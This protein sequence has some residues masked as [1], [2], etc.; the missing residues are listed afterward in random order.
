MVTK[1]KKK[2]KRREDQKQIFTNKYIVLFAILC[3]IFTPLLPFF[4]GYKLEFSWTKINGCFWVDELSPQ[5]HK[6][7]ES[8]WWWWWWWW[9][10][11]KTKGYRERGRKK[12]RSSTYKNLNL[13]DLNFNL[14]LLLHDDLFIPMTPKFS[15]G[16]LYFHDQSSENNCRNHTYMFEEDLHDLIEQASSVQT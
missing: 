2:R 1:P 8:A 4:L 5:K 3:H 14:R 10:L 6:Y 7:S 15:H 16:L 12:E 9:T 11:Q 13:L